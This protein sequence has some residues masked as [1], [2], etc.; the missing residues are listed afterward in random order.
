VD[1]NTD[2]QAV[3][4]P[5]PTP[6]DISGTVVT[7]DQMHTSTNPPVD[8]PIGEYIP[9]VEGPA[10]FTDGFKMPAPAAVTDSGLS[11]VDIAV[12]VGSVAL[13]AAGLVVIVI[14]LQRRGFLGGYWVRARFIKLGVGI[15]LLAAG[16][17][18]FSQLPAIG[19]D[20]PVAKTT[21]SSA[22]FTEWVSAKYALDIGPSGYEALRNGGT[23]V[24]SY[25]DSPIEVHLVKDQEGLSYLFNG[26][27]DEVPT[28]DQYADA[29]N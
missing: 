23:T 10:G 27:G 25:Y 5:E 1:E 6:D 14:A 3:N 15:A 7:D 11:L 8:Q 9:G 2:S 12:A 13:V 19:A 4:T 29:G 17:G 26:Y 24:V 22:E 20:A 28:A 16:A 21:S 18:I